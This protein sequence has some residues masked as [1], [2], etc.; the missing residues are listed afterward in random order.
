MSSSESSPAG[1]VTLK[2]EPPS[3]TCKVPVP[4]LAVPVPVK[5]PDRSCCAEASCEMVTL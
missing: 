4:T 5:A 2:L 3:E 1:M